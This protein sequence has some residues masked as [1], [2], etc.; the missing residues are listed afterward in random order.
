MELKFEF[1][2]GGSTRLGHMATAL[3]ESVTGCDH[4]L[5]PLRPPVEAGLVGGQWKLLWQQ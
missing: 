1:V 5:H 2:L 4:H 3:T